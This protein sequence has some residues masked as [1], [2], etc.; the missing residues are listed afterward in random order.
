M[1]FLSVPSS[2]QSIS[3]YHSDNPRRRLGA[4][5]SGRKLISTDQWSGDT[6]EVFPETVSIALHIELV[7]RD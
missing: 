6:G 5:I 2:H 3:N 1:S 7:L 4:S